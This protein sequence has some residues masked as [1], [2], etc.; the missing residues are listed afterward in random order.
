MEYN[1]QLL[2]CVECNKKPKLVKNDFNYV[3][4]QCFCGNSTFHVRLEEFARESWNAS[5]NNFLK[6]KIKI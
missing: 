2:K 3:K 4:Y 5:M 1:K 6:L